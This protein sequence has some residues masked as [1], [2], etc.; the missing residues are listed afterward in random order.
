MPRV[1]KAK[2]EVKPTPRARAVK[3]EAADTGV[4]ILPELNPRDPDTK[5]AGTEPVFHSQPERRQE[6]LIRSF[7]WYGRFYDR[8]MA[9]QQLVRYAQERKTGDVKILTRAAEDRFVMPICWLARMSMRGLILNERETLRI[10]EH[11]AQLQATVK[12]EV[13]EVVA[14]AKPSN[15]PNVQEIM[16]ERAQEAGGELEALF[17][18]FITDGK[19]G[20]DD[21]PVIQVLTE[22][23]IMAQHVPILI[24]VWRARRAEFEAV[25]AGK[26]AQLKEGYSQYTKIGIRN[27]IKFCDAVIA[28]LNS[29]VTVKRST[30]KPRARKLVSPEKQASKVKYLRAF[31][32]AQLKLD[33]VSLPPSKIVGASEVW[34]YDTG[35]RRLAYYVADQHIGTL[36]VK[37][38]TILGFDTTKS[39]IKTVRKPDITIP[40]LI[41]AGKPAARKIFTDLTTVG[42][43]ANGRTNASVIILRVS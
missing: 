15:R 25:Q 37:G 13:K 40:A 30:A 10:S 43:T 29:Y 31:K 1:A 16:R 27:I 26:D 32:D 5:Y 41:K 21:V 19:P 6:T 8:K 14:E 2:A 20:I 35:K 42:T 23:K 7:N 12:P 4:L 9:K 24:E 18:G 34:A 33:L 36:S 3:A 39:Q 22:R 28:G 11:I 38:T 17:D